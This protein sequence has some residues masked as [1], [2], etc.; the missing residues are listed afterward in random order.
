MTTGPVSSTIRDAAFVSSVHHMIAA[1]L[2]GA[3]YRFRS[4]AKQLLK[5][6]YWAAFFRLA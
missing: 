1:R 5:V 3:S 6:L 2:F 4:G